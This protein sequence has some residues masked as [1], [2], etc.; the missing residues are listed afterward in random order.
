MSGRLVTEGF[1][2]MGCDCA[3]AVTAGPGEARRAARALAAGRREVAACERTLSRFLPDSDLARVNRGAGSWVEVDARMARATRA[4]LAARRATG[5]RF[6][7]T[8]LP[9]LEAAGYDRSFE[10]ISER[11]ARTADGWRPGGRVEAEAGRVRVEEGL[12]IDLGGIAK[13]WSAER[14]LEAMREAWPSMRGGLVD[15]GG[16]L[17]LWG[18]TPERGPWRVAIADPRTPGATLGTLCVDGGGV[19]TSGRDRRRFGPGRSLHHLID[20]ATG[21]PAIGGP[22][23]VTV[24]A[25]QAHRAEAFATLLA[26]GG[27][28]AAEAVVAEHADIAAVFVPDAGEPVVLGDPRIEWPTEALTA[29]VA[30]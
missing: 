20:P 4:A 12:A 29:A 15:L 13:G 28:A 23:A 8:I 17:A 30:R 14:A 18:L 22:L 1:R 11:P 2:A 9:A 6:D 24:V 19:A 3:V 5:G 7:P 16:D 25:P 10:R 26:L 21:V 27:L